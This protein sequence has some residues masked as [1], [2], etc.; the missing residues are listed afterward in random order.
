MGGTRGKTTLAP[1]ASSKRSGLLFTPVRKSSETTTEKI[2]QMWILCCSISRHSQRIV[3][4][5]IKCT[6][7]AF[8]DWSLC[9]SGGKGLAL[10]PGEEGTPWPPVL[11]AYPPIFGIPSARWSWDCDVIADLPRGA[12]FKQDL[13]VNFFVPEDLSNSTLFCELQQT[14]CSLLNTEV[15]TAALL[16]M[17]PE[18]IPSEPTPMMGCGKWEQMP[19]TSFPPLRHL[20]KQRNDSPNIRRV[21]RY[22]NQ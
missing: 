3:L 9:D 15:L 6:H 19:V 1:K 10:H 13:F 7:S 12:F 20:R 18:Q 5:Q 16:T 22:R 4:P 11:W 2:S 21:W 14:R 8:T 17:L